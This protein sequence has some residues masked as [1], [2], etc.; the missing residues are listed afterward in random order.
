MPGN[1]AR[2][3]QVARASPN[4]PG[5]YLTRASAYVPVGVVGVQWL[6]LVRAVVHRALCRREEG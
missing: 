6:D 5:I 1:V 2:A 3:A 4:S